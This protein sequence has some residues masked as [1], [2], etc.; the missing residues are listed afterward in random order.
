MH[1]DMPAWSYKDK[2][3]ALYSGSEVLEKTLYVNNKKLYVLSLYKHTRNFEA[4][5]WGTVQ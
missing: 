4:K 2:P 5:V 1:N 3:Q